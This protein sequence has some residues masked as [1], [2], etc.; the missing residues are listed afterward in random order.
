MR[1]PIPISRYFLLATTLLALVSCA[2]APTVQQL[3]SLTPS[4]PGLID[5]RTYINHFENEKKYDRL[6]SFLKNELNAI[7]VM[8]VSTKQ[9]IYLTEPEKATIRGV[10]GPYGSQDPIADFFRMRQL[11]PNRKDYDP[12]GKLYVLDGIAQ[13]YTY[14]LVDFKRAQDYNKRAASLYRDISRYGLNR[15]PLSDHYSRNRYLYHTFFYRLAGP[16][17]SGFRSFPGRID[18]TTPFSADYIKKLRAMDFE[19][20]GRRIEERTAFLRSKLGEGEPSHRRTGPQVRTDSREGSAQMASFAGS[21]AE[22]DGLQRSYLLAKSAYEA[23]R[24]TGMAAYLDDII[25]HGERAI[26]APTSETAASR[27]R[28]NELSYWIGLAY[29]KQGNPSKGVE[30]ME[31]FLSGI[32]RWETMRTEAGER[33]KRVVETANR[34]EIAAARRAAAWQKAFSILLT[35]AG[36]GYAM[37]T[38]PTGSAISPTTQQMFQQIAQVS[39]DMYMD[40]G[41]RE[42][43]SE[44]TAMLRAEIAKF[45][46]PYSL[47]VNRYLDKYEMIDY[48]LELGKGYEATGRKTDALAQYEEAIRIIERQRSTIYTERQR[49]SFFAAKQEL[50]ERV[51]GLLTGLGRNGE[52]MEYLER[53][54]SRAFVDLLGS[55]RLKLKQKGQTESYTNHVDWQAEAETMVSRRGISND[56]ISELIKKAQR[57]VAVVGLEASQA[58]GTPEIELLSLSSVKT[59]TA[60]EIK[61]LAGTD[62]ALLAYFVSDTNLYIFLVQDGRIEAETVPIDVN[63]MTDAANRWRNLISALQDGEELAQYFYRLLV[64]PVASSITASQLVIIPH[65]VLHYVPFQALHDGRRYLVEEYAISYA[66][67]ATVLQFTQSKPVIGNGA[68]LVMG[69]PTRDLEFAEAEAVNVSALLDG[70]TLLTRED[71]KEGFLKRKGGE[72]DIIHL[73]THGIYDEGDPLNSRILLGAGGGDDG[74]LTT[75]ELFATSWRASLVTLSTCESGLSKRKT[76]DELIGLQRGMLFAGTQSIISSLWKVDDEATQFLMESFYRNLGSMPKNRAIQQAQKAA[77]ARYPHP[78]YWAAFNLTGA[79]T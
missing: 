4:R 42:M 43:E 71:A 45:I 13:I 25:L 53:A 18:L 1:R 5:S 33:R 46:T 8:E 3:P 7:K 29:L 55:T 75:R 20:L 49:I 22:Y 2:S 11:D 66:P 50:Y 65:G 67:S 56:Q 12:E 17:P 39:V 76:G 35:V 59:L 62:T 73:A 72:Y 9:G 61:T 31:A 38:T 47:K 10:F 40:A 74:E 21:I 32:D 52:A 68:A 64:S 6:L 60:E 57:G 30:Q 48:F 51:I 63:L 24:E 69:N 79:R 70:A 28:R 19:G 44:K 77:L 27:N 34:E 54:K 37:A 23:Y 16:Q 14:G 36:A 15:I 41:Q 58:L 26:A 78:F